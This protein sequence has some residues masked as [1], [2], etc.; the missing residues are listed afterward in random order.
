MKYTIRIKNDMFGY[1][2]NQTMQVDAYSE[3]EAIKAGRKIDRFANITIEKIEELKMTGDEL[4]DLIV[5]ELKSVAR[6]LADTVLLDDLDYDDSVR[7]LGATLEV[8]S[9]YSTT[10]DYV[11]FINSLPEEAFDALTPDEESTTHFEHNDVGINVHTAPGSELSHNLKNLGFQ[12]YMAMAEL[13]FISFEDMVKLAKA[14]A[15]TNAS[16]H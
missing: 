9:Y 5:T 1:E 13:G 8:I 11:N 2:R 12:A 6:M 16:K 14:Q 15:Q 3:A 7:T 10:H 4:D